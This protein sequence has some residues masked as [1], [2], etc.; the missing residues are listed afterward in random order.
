VVKVQRIE[1]TFH[2]S[3]AESSGTDEPVSIQIFRDAEREVPCSLA[4]SRGGLR[5]SPALAVLSM[6]R[7]P[8]R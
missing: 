2:T 3:A 4:S 5:Y 8:G 1:W 7:F 6:H